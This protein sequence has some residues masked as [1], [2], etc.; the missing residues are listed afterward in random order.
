MLILFLALCLV[1]TAF[2]I[3]VV[4]WRI[5]RPLNSALALLL[6]F[7][8]NLCFGLVILGL[9]T[10]ASLSVR[11]W[12]DFGGIAIVYFAFMTA[13]ITTYP[14]IEV[15]SP[16]LRLVNALAQAGSRG[17]SHSE[18]H[19]LIGGDL[20]I[21]PRIRDLLSEYLVVIN[22]DRLILSAKG[23]LIAR[24]FYAYRRVTGRE[25]GG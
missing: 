14:A 20:A 10:P 3:H 8:L 11:A 24:T 21:K 1:C 25:L 5:R 19:S 12:P 13:Y 23:R 9:W 15:D 4:I 17:I 18:V 16:T 7:A 6:I 2:A 22:G